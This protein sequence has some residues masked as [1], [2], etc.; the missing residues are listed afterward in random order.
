[1]CSIHALGSYL[2][3]KETQ[4]TDKIFAEVPDGKESYYVNEILNDICFY[5][6]QYE[7]ENERQL[8]TSKPESHGIRVGSIDDLTSRADV[9]LGSAA[10]RA[11]LL[12]EWVLGCG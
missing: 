7:S 2:L 12:Y 10:V 3:A 5:W 8:S 4:L 6:I 9:P 11:G 1:V